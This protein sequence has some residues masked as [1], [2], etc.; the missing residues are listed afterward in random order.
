MSRK[1]GREFTSIDDCVDVTI[2]GLKEYTK[3]RKVRLIPFIVGTLGTV[4]KKLES[5]LDEREIRG[6]IETIQTTGL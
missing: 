6:R 4:S 3:T 5:I 1:E 2:Q